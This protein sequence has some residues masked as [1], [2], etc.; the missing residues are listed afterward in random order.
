[1]YIW[2]RN[3]EYHIQRV[4]YSAK[5]AFMLTFPGNMNTW[6]LTLVAECSVHME[7]MSVEQRQSERMANTAQTW[8]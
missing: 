5:C 4:I 1:M 2:S 3:V 8:A 6:N 7:F